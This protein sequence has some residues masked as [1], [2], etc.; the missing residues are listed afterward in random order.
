MKK[1][2]ENLE[3]LR[4]GKMKG[5]NIY[6][7][8][9][10][11][12][13]LAVAMPTYAISDYI[14]EYFDGLNPDTHINRY[15]NKKYSLPKDTI[16]FDDIDSYVHYFNPD[17][18][19]SWNDW[20]NNKS[21]E[22]IYDDYV[23]AADRLYSSASS[24]DS[25]L[26]EG[27]A[28]AQGD[29]LMIQAD[30]NVVDS[31]VS[32]LTNYLKEKQLVLATKIMDINYHKSVYEVLLAD[33]SYEEALRKEEQA[34]NALTYGS[35][36]QVDMLTAKKLA[37]DARSSKVAAESNKKTYMRNLLINCG[38]A[39]DDNIYI[40]PFD[41]N[42]NFDINFI[43]LESDYQN[44]LSHSVQYEI[45]RRKRNNA[46][47]NEVQKEYDVLLNAAPQ[48]IYND[49]ETKY[50][51]LLD[52]LETKYNREVAYNLAVTNFTKAENEYKVG[53][54]S[55]KEYKTYESNVNT[56][57]YNLAMVKY[58]IKIALEEYMASA[59]GLGNC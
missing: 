17:V 5:N 19:N 20:E 50:S 58:D 31:Y 46:R 36:T 10:L 6:K 18:L 23:D 59:N 38:M 45:Y 24:G 54:I 8:L 57:L 30:K 39:Y 11:I 14:G 42:E 15:D 25:E 16:N 34:N 35:G 13:S 37:V 4:E 48:K 53:S 33:V 44:A 1:E 9:I 12:L 27:I 26:Q 21:S 56:T 3:M 32:F 43:N 29:A 49:L 47:T 2:R 22:K 28:N 41:L 40:A 51:N 52:L 7:I 55:E